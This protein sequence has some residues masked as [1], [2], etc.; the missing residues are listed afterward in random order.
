M[1]QQPFH[2]L[3]TN[4]ENNLHC[5]FSMTHEAATD[6]CLVVVVESTNDKPA[7]RMVLSLHNDAPI[8]LGRTEQQV[9]QV[10][11]LVLP[12][13]P[14]GPDTLHMVLEAPEC[15]VVASGY[16]VDPDTSLSVD[17]PLSLLGPAA[18]RELDSVNSALGQIVSYSLS[19]A[20]AAKKKGGKKKVYICGFN[21]KNKGTTCTIVNV[22]V[23]GKKKDKKVTDIQD[24]EVEDVDINLSSRVDN[25]GP[26][27]E[28]DMEP[29]LDLIFDGGQLQTDDQDERVH[30]F[31][32][33]AGVLRS[34][35]NEG[36]NLFI[37]V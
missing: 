26:I 29:Y 32:Q 15:E 1:H 20:P 2:G 9:G 27:T 7:G 12:I 3:R 11:T 25:D 17:I 28:L 4:P 22:I 8:H 23:C 14:T 13:P 36:D 5:A 18:S 35:A 24:I 6:R 34:V 33:L 30:D 37:S 16:I 21:K 31:N 10:G 19:A